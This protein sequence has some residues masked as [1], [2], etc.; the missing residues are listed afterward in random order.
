MVAIGLK[1]LGEGYAAK[2]KTYKED[3]YVSLDFT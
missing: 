1:F 2:E 3:D